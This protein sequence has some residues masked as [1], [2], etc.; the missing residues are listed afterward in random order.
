MPQYRQGDVLL[1]RV[2]RVPEEAVRLAIGVED[3]LLVAPGRDGRHAH[4]LVGDADVISWSTAPA[5]AAPALAVTT[6]TPAPDYLVIGSRGAR[7]VH[8]EHA[9]IDLP[10]GRYRIIR[11]RVFD[12]ATARAPFVKD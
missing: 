7:L 10:P 6:E 5:K 11:Q 3:P 9:P 8:E 4:R 1:E 12:P 2:D